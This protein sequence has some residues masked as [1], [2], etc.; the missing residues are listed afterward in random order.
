MTYSIGGESGGSGCVFAFVWYITVSVCFR[1][2]DYYTKHDWWKSY[3]WVVCDVCDRIFVMFYGK[4][5]IATCLRV[6]YTHCGVRL[7]LLCLRIFWFVTVS[8]A[9]CVLLFSCAFTTHTVVKRL[10]LVCVRICYITVS[11]TV[12]ALYMMAVMMMSCTAGPVY[13]EL[14]VF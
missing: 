2:R 5:C 12:S 9:V 8:L 6:Y 7:W 10:W 3:R 11:P 14:H 13:S 1:L 4:L